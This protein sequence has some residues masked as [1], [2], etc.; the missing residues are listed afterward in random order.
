MTLKIAED[1]YGLGSDLVRVAGD[2]DIDASTDSELVKQ[3][4]E[5]TELYDQLGSG[6]MV[7][8][9]GN[10]L[11]MAGQKCYDEAGLFYDEDIE[12]IADEEVGLAELADA[13]L[14]AEG[15]G[16]EPEDSFDKVASLIINE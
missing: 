8:M 2:T 3:A 11:K 4:E 6:E 9:A 1:L 10:L 14:E 16:Y 15:Y 7:K 12:K 13:A 5:Y